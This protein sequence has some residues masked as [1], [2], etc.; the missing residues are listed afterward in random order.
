VADPENDERGREWWEDAPR[1][2]R[3]RRAIVVVIAA[4][5]LVAGAGTYALVR[6]R[7]GAASRDAGPATDPATLVHVAFGARTDRADEIFGKRMMN[8]AIA[9]D[10]KPSSEVD[11]AVRALAADDVKQELGEPAFTELQRTVDAAKKAAQAEP[12][13]EL[14]VTNLEIATAKLD[15]ALIV[16]KKPY[17]VDASVLAKPDRRLVLLYEFTIAASDLYDSGGTRVRAVRL[18]RLDH[19]NWEHTLLGFVKPHRE[20]AVILLNQ[21][22]DQLVTDVIPAIAKDAPLRLRAPEGPEGA[23]A[24]TSMEQLAGVQLREDVRAIPQLDQ[25]ALAVIVD[26]LATRQALLARW[27]ERVLSRGARITLPTT[28]MFDVDVIASRLETIAAPNEITQLKRAQASIAAPEVMRAYADLLEAF[29]ASVERHE[30]QHRLDTS[31]PTPMPARVDEFFPPGRG[32]ATDRA[33]TRLTHE[34]SAYVAQIAR[35]EALARTTYSLLVRFLFDPNM[36]GGIESHVALIVTQELARELGVP[37]GPILV[38][39]T[40]DDAMLERA[41]AGITGHPPAKIAAAASQVWSRLFGAPL[42]PLVA[43][44]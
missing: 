32:M 38:N 21:I 41:H 31:H 4:V 22:E 16:A 43:S 9:L 5:L 17:F 25:K 8:L 30:V 20:Q 34:L 39:R 44:R 15:N 28:L 35:D 36:R 6:S 33:R 27:N 3:S 13:D 19:L 42:A 2:K 40:V 23:L 1:P 11:A 7:A 26:A 14:S 37:L 10:R 18:R 29:T 12:G 24:I